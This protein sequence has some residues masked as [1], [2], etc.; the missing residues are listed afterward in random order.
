MAGEGRR[1]MVN[2]AVALINSLV[3]VKDALSLAA[4]LALVFLVAFRTKKVPELFFGL[5]RDKLTRQQFA[6]LL[7]RFMTL[8]LVAF[9]ALL[10]LA[11]TSQV[12]SRLTTPNALTVNDLRNE[13]DKSE[14]SIEDTIKTHAE[15]QYNLAMEQLG[16]RDFDGA[17]TSL[18]NSIQAVPTL[19]A[20]EMLIYLYRQKGDYVNASEAWEQA[21]K[22]A[23][24]RGD[25][26]ALARL[27]NIQAPS[28]ISDPEGEHDLIGSSAPFPKGG[29]RYENA[30]TLSPGFYGCTE[31]RCN[32][33]FTMRLDTGQSVGLKVRNPPAGTG[34]GPE[35]V[36]Y[37][38]N[39]QE[40]KRIG[41]C[42]NA[43]LYQLDWT[44]AE[45]G[46]YF[47]AFNGLF[48]GAVFRVWVH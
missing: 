28:A 35:A 12:L 8:G 22:T 39:G 14:K 11:A 48:K 13:I 18:R 33:W 47:L 29:D 46:W 25:A 16:K 40:L 24:Q 36:L 10:V 4:F 21:E 3:Q 7:H 15:A 2:S 27:D 9:L 20:Q 43:A 32:G 6:G 34:C 17:I 1:D 41:S 42:N 26:L 30:T 19:T 38:T 44:A 31:D 5:L 23:Q 45:T 37:G